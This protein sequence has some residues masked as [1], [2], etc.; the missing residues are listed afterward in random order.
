MTKIASG[1][2]LDGL[3]DRLT[4]DGAPRI[5]RQLGIELSSKEILDI[6]K[7]ETKT[8]EAEVESFLEYF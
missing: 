3:A 8:S 1:A 5:P 7:I 4:D 6:L 2:S